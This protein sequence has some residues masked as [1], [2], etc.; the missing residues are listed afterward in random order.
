MEVVGGHGCLRQILSMWGDS[1]YEFGV[2]LLSERWI[3]ILVL[4]LDVV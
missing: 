1:T 3:N 2:T 4:E